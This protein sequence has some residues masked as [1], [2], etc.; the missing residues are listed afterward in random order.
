MSHVGTR[1]GW[2]AIL[3]LGLALLFLSGVRP[4]HAQSANC[5]GNYGG[6]VDG[7]V[8]RTP[9]NL[10][11]IDGPCTIQ[12]YP[13]S[14]P[15]AGSISWLSVN[16][17]LLVFN[18]V[19][20]IG[21]MSCDSNEHGDFVWFVNG[22]V[23]RSH[24]L[25]CA[26]LFAPVDK[27][28]KQNPTGPPFVSIGVPFTYTLTFPQL[29]NSLTGAVVNPNGSDVEVDQVTVTDNLNATGVSLSYVTSSAAWKGSGAPIPAITTTNTGGLL[30][31][32]NFPAIPPG[33]QI[34]LSVTVVLNN[35]VPPNSPG[36]QFFN[37]ANWTLGTTVGGT[38]HYPLPGQQGVSSPPLTIAAPTLVMTK[39]GPA[40]MSPGQP[41]QFTLNVQNTGNS[42][43]WNATIVDKLP[44]G[45]TGGMCT[46]APQILSAQVFQANGVTAVPGKGPL[47]AGTDYTIS[48]SG[49]PTCTLTLNMVSA[50]A[51][52]GPTQRLI[53]TYQTQLDAN[54]QNGASLTN[55]AGAT[56]WFSGPNS[57]AGRAG[58]TCT[59]TNGT[60]GVADCQDAHTVTASVPAL[61]ITK[62]V[63]VVGGGAPLPGATLAYLVHV[64]NTSAYPVDTVVIN[65]N[66]ATA[67]S[68]ALTYV[69]GTATMNGS[70]N[71]LNAS[72]NNISANYFG[73]YGPLAPGGTID[74]SFQATLGSTL[75]A[76]TTVTNTGVVLWGIPPQNASA[77]VSIQVVAPTP[78]A[79]TL[80]KGG[81]A[82]MYPG[83]LGKFT[84]NVQNTGTTDAWN[85]TVVDKLPTGA[86]G[87][88]CT[89]TPQILSAQ[90]FMSDGVTPA[91]G[92]G[93][94]V[95]G[96]DFTVSYSGAPTC[97]LSLNML[98][99]AT[100]IRASQRLII[101]YQTQLD[102]N[103]QVGATLTNVAGAT[104][105]YNGS[106][107]TAGRQAYTCALSDGTPGALDCQDAHTVTVVA[108]AVTIAKQVTVV[109]GGPAVA[110]ATL[111]YLVHVTNTSAN[112]VN[113]VVITDDLNAAGAGALTYVAGT[114]TMNG[115]PSGVG[116]A[117]NLITANYS[118]PLAPG[119]T[120]DLAFQ[121]T[122]GGTLAAGTTV[123]N[124]GVVAW[125][126]PPQTASG[127]VSIQVASPPALTLTKGGPTTMLI[128]QLG[129]FTLNAQNTGTSDAWNATIVDRLPTGATGGMC[130]ATPLLL[131]ARV[132]M[133]DGVTPVPGKGA[134]T[135]G[136]DY[137]LSYAGAP[138]CTLTLNMLSAAAAIGPSQRLIITYQTQLDPNTQNGGVT[139]TNVAGATQWYNAPSSNTGRQSYICTL[140]N[141]TPGVLD[142]QD[143]H[144]VT[145]AASPVTITKQVTVDGGGLAVAGAT[146]DYLVHVTNASANPVNPV[147]VTDDLNAAGP[148]ALTYVAGTATMNGSPS[149]VSVVS[150]VITANYSGPLAPG[151]TIDL[152]FRATLGSTLAAGTT[153]TNTGVVTWNNPPQTASGSVSI[154]VVTPPA[155]TLTKGGQTTTYI[156]QQGQFTLD[157]QNTGTTDAWNATILDK[158][159]TGTSGGMCAATPQILSAQVFQADGVTAVPGKGPLTA[160][161]DYTL[162]YAGAPT[163]TLTLNLLSAA[164]VIGPTQRL[165]ITY[166]TRLDANT[167][168]GIT[169][170][171][172]AGATQW[173]NAPSSNTGRQSYTCTLTNGTPGVL[174][175]QDAHTVTV[176]TPDV[177]IIKQVTVV[178]GGSVVGGATLAYVVHV[179]N[180]SVNPVNPVVITDD[181]N[182]AGTGVLTYVAGTAT[183]NGSVVGVTVSGNVI[184]ANY[185]ATYGPL[186]PGATIDLR[187]YAR[188]GNTLTTGMPVTNTGVVTWNNPP[189]TA[190]ASVSVELSIPPGAI[191]VSKTTPLVDVT[192]GQL[193][194]Y[195]ITATNVLTGAVQGVALVDTFPAG[196]RYIK[197]SARLDDMPAEPT[198]SGL[199]L[200]WSNL[201]FAGGAHHTIVLLLAVGAGVGEGQF[202][203]RAQ[204]FA[205]VP[206]TGAQA[207]IAVSGA[208]ALAV[209]GAPVSR[210][211][212][213]AS[214]SRTPVNHAQAIAPV[215]GS[216]VSSEATATVVVVPD[217]TFDCT[218][219]IGKVFDDVNGDGRQEAG[220]K[221]LPG[222]R[223]VTTR[224]LAA[225]TDEFGRFHITC[226]ITPLEGRGS[227]FAL[228]LDD[229]TLPSGYRPTT[230]QVLVERA[231][232]GK[233]LRFEFGASIHR[234]VGLDL[235]D[236]VFEPGSTDMRPEWRPRLDLLLAE[237]R[238][239]RS[240]LHLSYVADVEDR[241]LVD[242][243][244][245]A[246]A[247]T[248][249][250]AWRKMN[251]CYELTVEREVFW[252]RGGPPKE[253]VERLRGAK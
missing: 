207:G 242:R 11:Q 141:G 118:G 191:T 200:T 12:N 157:V 113:P 99:A 103:T 110:G 199:Q 193:V 234:V 77:S 16:N 237:L 241:P 91:P 109:G 36:T 132:F 176:A 151:G 130:T 149:G 57:S 72:G 84:L 17:T 108:S 63:T 121:A 169:L 86:T 209:T 189:Q 38:F 62:Q 180:T 10:L 156:G 41:G 98:S 153:V 133:A 120:V 183:V 97:T 227:N 154:Q 206:G 66:L 22:S 192:R 226:A 167:Q 131:S 83:Q 46:T 248:I 171:N 219:V 94:L 135:A 177:T 32:S 158:L 74:L 140:T 3:L 90:V 160:G 37:T 13:A 60:P 26:S 127:S 15:D 225:V 175:C 179:T 144:T 117:G 70:P 43:A 211:Q 24:I 247:Q 105:W 128:G 246:V 95:A 73:T 186:A 162:T 71:G 49:A 161:T 33:Q 202:V 223:L 197:G 125:N 31:F 235:S 150:N 215:V 178:G 196:F 104:Q 100:V 194:P 122:L 101:T 233:S 147:V 249:S 245:Q 112:P 116:V 75:A 239:S 134:L 9:P 146:L 59:L 195:I 18:N 164:A 236:A 78:P 129:Q 228:K 212:A 1:R 27:I 145:V 126:I 185:S 65:D 221:G 136:A 30:T 204:A 35:A 52:I 203:N 220:E 168:N 181:L 201:S 172:V 252:L 44:T 142:C 148:G 51:A 188:L 124:T 82:T 76:G 28:D 54:T 182:A 69:A 67:G 8:Y 7:N 224:G 4:A 106:S 39:G 163:C 58:Y 20:F 152:R 6:V 64:T 45:A 79:L 138:T 229:R 205:E 187:F 159:P 173:Y 198:V 81:P 243:R 184:T 87:G 155:L 123:T 2:M 216:A 232:R 244:L 47:A 253:P 89:A 19:D 50:A 56:Q 23:T 119:A 165:V 5:V 210:T 102:A 88:M 34:V 170:T 25:K 107:S 166:Q 139:L 61:T 143:A 92:K 250:D 137:T 111:A 218:D 14:N 85:A 93:P 217:T 48:Y 29:I 231:T 53:V 222:V 174:D 21:N 213:P 214:A 230:P 40:T 96:T 240:V 251:C 115:S 114:A 42:D 190:S 55:V 68:G 80:T 238:K 208:Q